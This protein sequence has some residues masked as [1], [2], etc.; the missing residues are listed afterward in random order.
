[1]ITTPIAERAS[2]AAWLPPPPQPPHDPLSFVLDGRIGWRTAAAVGVAVG[3]EGCALQLQPLPDST[4]P[5][6]DG[7]WGGLALPAHLAWVGAGTQRSLVLFDITGQRLLRLN[8]CSACFEPWLCMTPSDVRWPQQFGGMTGSA[9]G[10]GVIAW[11]DLTRRVVVLMQGMNGALRG[12]WQAAAGQQP[13]AL[14]FDGAGRLWVAEAAQGELL[15]IDARGHVR[16]RLGGAGAVS[17]LH[18][19]RHGQPWVLGMDG[20][21]RYAQAGSGDWQAVVGT[22]AEHAHAFCELGVVI[23]ADGSVDVGAQLLPP[24]SPWWMGSD[25][26]PLATAPAEPAPAYAEPGWWCSAALDSEIADCVWD[27][28]SVDA[29]LPAHAALE[30]QVLSS[31]SELPSADV[32]AHAGWRPALHVHG[33]LSGSTSLRGHDAML[34][35]EPGRWMWLRLRLWAGTGAS[36]EPAATPHVLHI[37]VD[38]PRISWRRYL[39]AIFGAEPVSAEFSD[40]FMAVFD[41]TLRSVEEQIDT[42]ARLFDPASAPP[43]FVDFL[44]RWIG[45]GAALALPLPLR[46]EFIKHAGRAYTW[47]GTPAGLRQT[48]YLLLGLTRWSGWQPAATDCVPCT[49]AGTDAATKRFAWRP[50]RL[51]L[52]HFQLRR[53]MSLDTARL[54]DHA[55]LWGQRIVNRSQLGAGSGEGAQLGRSQLIT[56]P[57]PWRDP[58]HV[59]AHKLS[60]FVPAARMCQP[61]RARL[62]Q[63]LLALEM[64]AHVQLTLHAVS[65]GLRVGVQSAIGLDA[66]IGLRTQPVQLDAP[67]LALGR[68]TVLDPA[69]PPPTTRWAVGQH[70]LGQPSLAPQAP[71]A[72]TSNRTLS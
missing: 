34:R 27:R 39:P 50:P 36:S 15:R 12:A 10:D 24:Q 4:R 1:M 30:I 14:A 6:T 53:W 38:Y 43:A 35:A 66:V 16:Q 3:P 42:Q 61:A 52:E 13:T 58:L 31:D 8:R 17:Q 18:F 32:H 29:E 70:R 37:E 23:A 72:A 59:T 60:I 69:G 64:P 57:D 45:A 68:A 71:A 22:P 46:R 40:R 5:W 26:C 41:R 51:L 44:G 7:S 9:V 47:R 55:R 2:L 67:N 19:D 62:L 20:R 49:D 63:Q 65:P 28:V 48:L 33:P 21:V 56:T 11:L 25:G 54:S